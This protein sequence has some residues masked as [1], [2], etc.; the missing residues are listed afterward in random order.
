MLTR[1]VTASRRRFV[2]AVCS[3]HLPITSYSK[4]I[5]GSECSMP[6]SH[7]A[8]HTKFYPCVASLPGHSERLASEKTQRTLCIQTCLNMPWSGKVGVSRQGDVQAANSRGGWET[9][10]ILPTKQ[11]HFRSL[12]DNTVVYSNLLINIPQCG[13]RANTHTA[14]AIILSRCVGVGVGVGGWVCNFTP[15]LPP[16]FSLTI[17]HSLSLLLTHSLT[18]SASTCFSHA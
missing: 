18:H 4:S 12:P 9:P 7:S 16:S 11:L 13:I 17:P 8:C 6:P 2:K 15:P 3:K 10:Y 14:R 1:S 5:I